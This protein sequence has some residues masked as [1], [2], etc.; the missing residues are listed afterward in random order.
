VLTRR[1]AIFLS[2]LFFSLISFYYYTDYIKLHTFAIA[3]HKILFAN[4]LHHCF[5]E[6][7][8]GHGE[9]NKAQPQ[10]KTVTLRLP[11]DLYETVQKLSE[12]ETRSFNLQVIHLL[13]ISLET[14]KK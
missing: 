6:L 12:D 13:K 10:T 9:E 14:E 4:L 3:C 11:V 8:I 1:Y 5:E 7:I 2:I